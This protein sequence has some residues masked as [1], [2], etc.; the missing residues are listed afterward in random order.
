MT[1]DK[2]ELE[3]QALLE[4]EETHRDEEEDDDN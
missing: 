1:K 4:I 3:R 2:S